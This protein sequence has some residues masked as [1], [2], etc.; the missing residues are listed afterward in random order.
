MASRTSDAKQSPGYSRR[1]ANLQE[2]RPSIFLD[3]H[4]T[5]G[6]K[7]ALQDAGFRTVE[8]AR[9]RPEPSDQ[10]AVRAEPTPQ[11]LHVSRRDLLGGLIHEYETPPRHDD[12]VS[13]PHGVVLPPSCL[14][15][16]CRV[17]S[18]PAAAAQQAVRL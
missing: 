8:V 10:S 14:R 17:A 11:D 7:T 2:R 5:P 15:E 18:R 9:D 12:R 4:I 6:V 13:A 1:M 16:C 3:E